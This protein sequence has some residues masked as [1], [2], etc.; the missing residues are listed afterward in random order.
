MCYFGGNAGFACNLERSTSMKKWNPIEREWSPSITMT[1]AVKVI[2]ATYTIVESYIIPEKQMWVG[3]ADDGQ[4]VTF[5]RMW[6]KWE[7]WAKHQHAS[8]MRN[9]HPD[10]IREILKHYKARVV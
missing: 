4:K 8:R 5:Q 10:T 2:M 9:A 7:F 6:K 1:E 3:I